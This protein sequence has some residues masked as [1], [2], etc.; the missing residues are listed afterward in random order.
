MRVVLAA[1]ASAVAASAYVATA[2]GPFLSA[3]LLAAVIAVA[4]VSGVPVGL[5]AAAQAP[6][7]RR[8]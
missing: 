7:G 1:T 5:P 6:K 2:F 3:A 4:D 8:R